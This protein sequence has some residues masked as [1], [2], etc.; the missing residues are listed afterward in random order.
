M[1]NISL[2]RFATYSTEGLQIASYF[3]GDA[4][5]DMAILV[6]EE[7]ENP[8]Q[9]KDVLIKFYHNY[10][11]G[12]TDNN[13]IQTKFEVLFGMVK[14]HQQQNQAN[15][16]SL[17]RRFDTYL[18]VFKDFIEVLDARMLN[19]ENNILKL[20]TPTKKGV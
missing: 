8:K 1:G 17:E 3:G 13:F 15:F 6:L 20:V 16:I 2:P 9:F 5:R 18:D 19:L 4:N 11:E 7:A 14:E 12:K 10:A